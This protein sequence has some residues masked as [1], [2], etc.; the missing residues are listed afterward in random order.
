MLA[1]L[2]IHDFDQIAEI[3]R[4]ANS[5]VCRQSL[6]DFRT[7]IPRPIQLRGIAGHEHPATSG[8][9]NHRGPGLRIHRRLSLERDRT[10]L[11]V[12]C[13]K[14][15]DSTQIK[16]Q[17]GDMKRQNAVVFQM[18]E[19]HLHGFRGQQMGRNG[20]AGECIQNQQ[21]ELLIHF[22]FQHKSSVPGTTS[23]FARVSLRNVK[24][25]RAS[26]VTVSLIS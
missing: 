16:V 18:T 8:I 12:G 10:E 4:P 2:P 14:F 11:C 9:G 20:I 25:F 15:G 26:S 3:I 17:I 24:C 13:Q 7:L 1:K 19:I 5:F 6:P 22:L 21:I 23:T